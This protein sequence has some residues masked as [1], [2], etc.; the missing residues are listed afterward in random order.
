MSCHPKGSMCMS[1]TKQLQKCTYVFS[2][3]PIMF[4]YVGPDGDMRYVVK[5]T[6]YE[7]K[8]NK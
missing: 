6:Y 2:Q 7:N 5:C 3:M 1:C 4:K 8:G